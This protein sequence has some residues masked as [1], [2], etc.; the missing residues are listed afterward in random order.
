MEVILEQ[1]F[2]SLQL[3]HEDL[4][5]VLMGQISTL[6]IWPARGGKEKRRREYKRRKRQW[7]RGI[8]KLREKH[9]SIKN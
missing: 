1:W 4:W 6:T 3:L 8:E 5:K 9:R 2:A 7:E